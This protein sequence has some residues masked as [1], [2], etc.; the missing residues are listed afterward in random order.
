MNDSDDLIDALVPVVKAF[1]KVGIRHF[2]GGSIASSFHGA[3]RSTMDVDLIAESPR[4]E[5][6]RI[7]GVLW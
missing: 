4:R 6:L 3:T 7:R 5:Y 2:V 1:Q